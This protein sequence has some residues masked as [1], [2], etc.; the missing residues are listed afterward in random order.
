MLATAAAAGFVHGGLG[1]PEQSL[2]LHERTLGHRDPKAYGE[3]KRGLVQKQ[4]LTQR[5]NHE[6]SQTFGARS[7]RVLNHHRKLRPAQP[8]GRH[9]TGGEVPLV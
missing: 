2:L 3:M 8:R 7:V 6:L 9:A 5:V 4:A 1:V